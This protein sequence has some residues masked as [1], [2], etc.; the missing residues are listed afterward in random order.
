MMP[1]APCHILIHVQVAVRQNVQ[2][3]AFLI[4]DEHGHRILKLLAKAHVEHA[5]VQ[6]TT[7][8]TYVKPTRPRKR[9]RG[10]ARQ[11]QVGGSSEHDILQGPHYTSTREPTLLPFG[12]GG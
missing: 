11:H 6:W 3:G 10:R 5:G 2:A 9:S 1:G 8:H 4:A 12:P 7:P